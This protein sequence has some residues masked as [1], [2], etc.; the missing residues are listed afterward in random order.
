MP[1]VKLKDQVGDTQT[2]SEV[3]YVQLN[4]SDGVATYVSEHLILQQVQADWTEENT[5]SPAYI[6]HKPTFPNVG[7]LLPEIDEEKDEGKILGIVNG[8]WQKTDMPEAPNVPTPNWTAEEGQPGYI[9]NKPTIPNPQVQTDWN[10]IQEEGA[11]INLAVIKNK[12]TD[13]VNEQYVKERIKEIPQPNWEES[14]ETS[15]AFIQNKPFSLPSGL[16]QE[17]TYTAVYNSSDKYYVYEV[18]NKNFALEIGKNYGVKFNGK[19]YIIQCEEFPGKFTDALSGRLDGLGNPA[20]VKLA[21]YTFKPDVANINSSYDFFITDSYVYTT[22]EGEFTLYLCESDSIKKLDGLL[23]PDDLWEK[24][25]WNETIPSNPGYI[26][27]RPTKQELQGN[28]DQNDYTKMDY[29]KNKPFGNVPVLVPQGNYQLTNPTDT[30]T[31]ARPLDGVTPKHRIGVGESYNVYYGGKT[32]TLQS[33][34]FTVANNNSYTNAT[35]LECIGTP[36]LCKNGT[37]LGDPS[38]THIKEDFPSENTYPFC[39]TKN[40]VYIRRG[41]SDSNYQKY[42]FE[43]YKTDG[44]LKIDKK[45]L[46]SDAFVQANWNQTDSSAVDFIKNKPTIPAAQIQANWAQTDVNAKDY[47]KNKPETLEF[48]QSDW[49]ETDPNK[50]SFILNK[51]TIPGAQIQADYDQLDSRQVDFIKNKIV[52]YKPDLVLRTDLTFTEAPVSGYYQA[53]IEFCIEPK[54][55]TSYNIIYQGKTYKASEQSYQ[56]SSAGYFYGIGNT[57]LAII[58]NKLV[59]VEHNYFPEVPFFIDTEASIVYIAGPEP[60]QYNRG[61]RITE[62]DNVIKLDSKFLRGSLLPEINDTSYINPYITWTNSEWTAGEFPIPNWEETDM[63]SSNFIDNKPFGKRSGYFYGTKALEVKNENYYYGLTMGK[64]DKTLES[65]V[66]GKVVIDNNT[67]QATCKKARDYNIVSTID[68][69]SGELDRE[70]LVLG[71]VSL[72]KYSPF[73]Q[74]FTS[75]NTGENY[76]F[77]IYRDL[78]QNLTVVLFV[79]DR[80]YTKVTYERIS[81]EYMKIDKKYLPDDL[82]IPTDK[83]LLKEDS[84]A[85]A[86]ATG[87]KIQE[88]KNLINKVEQ[89]VRLGAEYAGQL[90]Y[91]GED[92]YPSVLRLGRG[93]TI[94]NGVLMVVESSSETTSELDVGILDTMILPDE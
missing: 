93:L 15:K 61:F 89:K 57:D 78:M 12:P 73:I 6:Q 72:L 77:V 19:S 27:N 52:G 34:Q 90:V 81:E 65:G 66:T 49:N 86:K 43:A 74:S 46:P 38:F 87:E 55:A 13:L 63:L 39:I 16:I 68:N 25:D 59:N 71:N 18:E 69:G 24:P 45:W 26:K 32:Y 84:P 11:E 70:A 22:K 31:S 10:A 4:T 28:W 53:P 33:K 37:H 44:I 23:V 41:S 47:I 91:V 3:D 20:L 8:E 79:T 83:Y 62:V 82:V 58:N 21:G 54:H 42:T 17:G 2:F 40:A 30:S 60:D 67:Y 7:D 75:S 29:I 1:E 35:I 92:G 14:D 88:T 48:V 94:K 80:S 5:E 36:S 64:Y 9:I 85:D 50:N 76:C 56:D 51:P